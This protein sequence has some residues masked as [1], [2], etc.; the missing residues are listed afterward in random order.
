MKKTVSKPQPVIVTTDK[1][2]VFFGYC[3]DA[4][5]DPVVLGQARMC[6]YWSVGMKGIM[7]LASRG[8]DL[9]CKITDAVPSMSIPGRDV[10]S[11]LSCTEEAVQ[12]W[13]A[14]PWK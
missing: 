14:Q 2:G 7:G 5:A 8:P 10:T 11:V 4:Q 3:A 12:K 9:E 1:R 13:E 6:V